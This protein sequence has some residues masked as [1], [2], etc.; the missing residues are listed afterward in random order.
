[1]P[2]PP[3]TMASPDHAHTLKIHRWSKTPLKLCY[4]CPAPR[5]RDTARVRG[6]CSLRP[7][8]TVFMP[9]YRTRMA[10]VKDLKGINPRGTL[11]RVKARGGLDSW[12]R[13]APE[14]RSIA[15]WI[16]WTVIAKTRDAMRRTAGALH[17]PVEDL[18]KDHV[19][20]HHNCNCPDYAFLTFPRLTFVPCGL[21]LDAS[22]MYISL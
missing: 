20:R 22:S 18:D 5:T 9:R 8:K 14:T 21:C 16:R 12:S 7:R 6:R 2:R 13:L 11:I 15:F 3:P 19:D 1:M 4:L 17:E 10:T